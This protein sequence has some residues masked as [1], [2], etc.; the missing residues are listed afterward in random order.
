MLKNLTLILMMCAIAITSMSVAVV[1]AAKAATDDAA[2]MGSFV[3][4]G[5][6]FTIDDFLEL[7]PRKIKKMTGEKLSIKEAIGLKVAQKK[8]KK[9][10]KKAAKGEAGGEG[11]S[12]L[13]ALLLA[14]FIGGLGIHRFYLGYTTIGIIQL[15]TLGGCGIWALIDIIRIALGDLGPVDGIPYEET[16]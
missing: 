16:L 4:V 14:V 3:P 7:T 2:L 1:P 11:K 10:Q 8:I 9:A 13:V 6:D 15:L 12:Q 5:E